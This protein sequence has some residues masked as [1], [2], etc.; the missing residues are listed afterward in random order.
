MQQA[1]RIPVDNDMRYYLHTPQVHGKP[2]DFVHLVH[3]FY[4]ERLSQELTGRR[5]AAARSPAHCHLRRNR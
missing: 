5:E 4:Y 1:V 2:S 3:T